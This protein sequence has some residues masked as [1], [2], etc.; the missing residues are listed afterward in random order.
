MVR[1]SRWCW[2]LPPPPFIRLTFWKLVRVSK[3]NDRTDLT[4]E[5]DEAEDTDE[6]PDANEW[7]E[8]DCDIE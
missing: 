3:L 7:L 2:F 5:A 6:T 1:V 4:E 8:E